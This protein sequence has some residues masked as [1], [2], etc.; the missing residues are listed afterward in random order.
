MLLNLCNVIFENGGAEIF[1]SVNTRLCVNM[2][3]ELAGGA[4]GKTLQPCPEMHP[5]PLMSIC[6]IYRTEMTSG[7]GA[8]T[9][10]LPSQS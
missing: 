9:W 7:G 3:S 2:A 8:C 6:T 10:Q 1:V 4:F 5:P